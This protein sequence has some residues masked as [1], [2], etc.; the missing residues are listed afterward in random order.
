MTGMVMAA[1][2]GVAIMRW[3][4]HEDDDDQRKEELAVVDELFEGEGD[5]LG[6]GGELAGAAR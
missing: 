1:M 5:W 2:M 6:A 4:K 3:W